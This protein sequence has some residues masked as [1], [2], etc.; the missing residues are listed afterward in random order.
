MFAKTFICGS[1]RENGRSAALCEELFSAEIERDPTKELA[2]IA[3]SDME[4]EGCDGCDGCKKTFECVID[5][6]MQTVYEYINESEELVI[7][8]PVYMASVPSQFKA[9]LDRLQPYFWSDARHG[10]LRPAT[11]HLVGEGSDPFGTKAAQ[12]TIASAMLVAG[13]EIKD[14]KTHINKSN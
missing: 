7:V 11:V 13:Y 5:D 6:E 1:P 4:I 9:F 14:V 12:D 2:L 3:I 10:E 8:S